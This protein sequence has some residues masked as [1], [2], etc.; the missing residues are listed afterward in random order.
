MPW[1]R[2]D[3]KLHRNDKV[4][5]L[6]KR[7][8]VGREALGVWTFWLSWCLDD[9]AYNGV[10]PAHELPAADERGVRE[11]LDVGLWER[12]GDD[13]QIHD[14]FAYAQRPDQVETKRRIDR[15]RLAAKRAASRP[16]V[17]RESHATTPRQIRES[18]PPDPVPDPEPLQ[19]E[20]DP[21][22]AR[23]AASSADT[24]AR[25]APP[26]RI[27][28]WEGLEAKLRAGF[29][30]RYVPL[31]AAAPNQ[32]RLSAAVVELAEWIRVTAPLRK[33]TE[34]ALLERLLDGFFGNA[35]ARAAAFAP[36]W[37]SANPREFL[38]GEE[39]A[40]AP[41]SHVA[42]IAAELEAVEKEIAT[43]KRKRERTDEDESRLY[44]LDVAQGELSM[45]LSRAKA[46]AA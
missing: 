8:A 34:E 44:T 15:E 45:N 39:V 21:P 37:L 9:P 5:E 30:N 23:L 33:L 43:L 10:V 18:P 22:R 2:L 13:Y 26:P 11:L 32:R 25:E 41:D 38:D 28:E 4:R 36:T 16:D 29:T 12:A 7:K 3:D 24:R 19:P 14:F 17:A 40:A 1:G 20:K 35:K 6:R 27:P 42:R 46:R 31:M